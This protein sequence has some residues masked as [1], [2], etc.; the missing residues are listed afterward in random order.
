MADV[1]ESVQ[2]H[3]DEHWCSA[4]YSWYG[5]LSTDDKVIYMP[6]EE[7]IDISDVDDYTKTLRTCAGG[8]Q[9]IVGEYDEEIFDV[10]KGDPIFTCDECDSAYPTEERAQ[11]CC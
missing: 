10:V 2:E 9:V 1:T 11:N 4:C 5:G 8:C 6:N 7:W 3:G